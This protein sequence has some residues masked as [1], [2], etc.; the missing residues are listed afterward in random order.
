MASTESIEAVHFP[1]TLV[2]SS[3]VTRCDIP[4]ESALYV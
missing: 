3:H 4:D 1:K 2:S